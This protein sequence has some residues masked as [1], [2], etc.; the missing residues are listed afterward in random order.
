MSWQ[1]RTRQI[2]VPVLTEYRH[3]GDWTDTITHIT[4]Y[5]KVRVPYL[6]NMGTTYLST[7]YL[8][9][10]SWC[11]GWARRRHRSRSVSPSNTSWSRLGSSSS[12]AAG[13]LLAGA[14]SLPPPLLQSP[15]LPPSPAAEVPSPLAT[16][17]PVLWQVRS[18]GVN[19]FT[20]SIIT[21]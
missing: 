16:G 19:F 10:A 17:S 11:S 5:R 9:T 20:C 8:S 1:L 6:F 18:R 12:C 21:R 14:G 15:P 2:P 7:T 3:L 4:E 13:P